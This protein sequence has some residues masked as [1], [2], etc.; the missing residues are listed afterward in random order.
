MTKDEFFAM[1]AAQAAAKLNE[2]LDE[3]KTPD[4]A[5]AECGI[6]K[7]DLAKAQIFL[8]KGKYIA[9]AW[10]GYTSTKSTGNEVQGDSYAK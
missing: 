10:G 4:E 8:V 3:G 6:T 2:L 5:M 9:R 1:D 7:A